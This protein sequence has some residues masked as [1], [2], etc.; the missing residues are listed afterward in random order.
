MT[1]TQVRRLGNART[2]RAAI[3]GVQ[4]G[5]QPATATDPGRSVSRPKD[6]PSG[7]H[8]LTW[9]ARGKKGQKYG[10]EFVQ[11]DGVPCFIGP[12]TFEADGF[13]SG[14]CEFDL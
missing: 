13:D 14:D 11:P 5:W 12:F 3:D 4:L 9:F 2:R 10:F 8:V 1:I 6:L 7:R